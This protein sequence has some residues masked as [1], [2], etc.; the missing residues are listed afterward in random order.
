MDLTPSSFLSVKSLSRSYSAL[1]S[2]SYPIRH[3]CKVGRY[4]C[5]E[6]A[7]GGARPAKVLAEGRYACTKAAEGGARPAKC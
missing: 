3:S 7:E 2:V 1:L 5:T 4:A 6:A